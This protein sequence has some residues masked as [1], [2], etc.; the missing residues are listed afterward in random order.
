MTLLGARRVS[1]TAP[2]KMDILCRVNAQGEISRIFF[3]LGRYWA[4]GCNTSIECLVLDVHHVLLLGVPRQFVDEGP[5]L[6]ASG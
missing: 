5:P 3:L 4:A 6:D 1:S 2:R